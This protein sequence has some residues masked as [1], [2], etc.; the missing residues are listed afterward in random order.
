[1]FLPWTQNIQAD[2][3]VTTLQPD[4]RPQV[5]PSAIAGKIEKW[6]VREGELVEKGD[7]I[8][9][10]SEVKA[11]YIDP[12]LVNRARS[13]AEAKESAVVSYSGK[14]SALE[15]QIAAMRLELTNKREQLRNKIEQ[16]KLQIEAYKIDVVAAQTDADIAKN[17]LVRQEEL[18]KQGL[19]SLT[20]VEE[21]R[22][23]F[24]Q[25][26]AKLIS[27]KNKL[28]TSENKLLN[29]EIALINVDNEY[30]SK[31]AKAESD[32]YSTLSQKF[33]AEGS[34][35]KLQIEYESYKRRSDFYFITAPQR[36]YVTQAVK[37]GIG[38]II[39]EGDPLVTIMPADYELA[40]ELYI[41]PMDLPL[42]EIGKEV[43]FIFDG[44]PAFI[45]SGWPGQSFGTFQ[46]EIWAID[47]LISDK[48]NYRILVR[49]TGDKE[50]PEA[51]Q[52]GSGA[53]GIALLND[54]PLWY[55]IWRQLNG[56]PPD[57]YEE[58]KY[59]PGKEPKLK[60]PIKSVK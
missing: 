53:Q 42:V 36:S 50:W 10:I 59:N 41:R 23:K 22:N 18:Y 47:R 57:Y 27:A 19:K 25:T 39:K 32:K 44:W 3:T 52:V 28:A 38:E 37:A 33:D 4:Q 5:I 13:R 20:D 8:V 46:G 21:K 49:P 17:Q 34:V 29:A 58:N 12:E 48:G 56:F 9:Q 60:A 55:E 2:G 31:I 15:N 26:N 35:N 43:R 16:E 45:F 40:V 24:Q 30:Q 51:L 14:V 11:E 6:Y 54:V 1:M 7:T